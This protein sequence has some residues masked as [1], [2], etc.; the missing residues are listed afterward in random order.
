MRALPLHEQDMYLFHN[1]TNYQAYKM[2]GAH[3][4]DYK[5]SR[6]V[7]FALWVDRVKAV[8]VVGDFN[9][10]QPEPR[11]AMVKQK[12]SNIWTVFIPRLG[13]GD[14]Y[15]Y[16]IVTEQG[17]HILK[18][19]PFAF[20]AELP[21][22]TSSKVSKLGAYKWQ[23]SK[24]Q[25]SLVDNINKPML[26]YE[27]HLGSWRL[28]EN[29]K[30]FSYRRL[31]EELVPYAKEMGYTH[32]E[33]M[34]IAEHPFDGSWGYQ[35]TG[36]YA[37]TS[38]YGNPDDFKY[39]VDTCHQNDISVILD[40]SP[41][42]FC[43]DAH[44][45][46]RFNGY[47]LF[48]SDNTLRAENIEWGT[49]NFDYGRPE[50]LSF[51]ISNAIYWLEEFHV[52]GLRM[53]AVSNMLYLNY[54]RKDGQW[55]PNQYGGTGNL[56]A[57]EFIKNLNMAVFKFF[58]HALMIAEESTDWPRVSH[59]VYMSGLGF[60]YKWNMGWMNDMLKYMSMDPIYRRWHHNQLTFSLMYAFSEKYV[61]PLSHDEV[62]HGKCSL[63]E[64]MPGPYE[65]KFR[66]LKL[67]LAYWMAHPGKKLLFMGG[68]FAQFVEWKYQDSLD[69][70]LLEYPAHRDFHEYMKSLNHFY[71]D[72]KEM[73]EQDC[74]PQGFEW[75]DCHD[76][77]YSIVS[78][79]R[80]GMEK[81]Y[82]IGIFN[83]TPIERHSYKIGVPDS[84]SYRTIFSS[85]PMP[86]EDEFV[87]DAQQPLH[88]R[89]QSIV[90]NLP[91]LSAI[92]L[93]RTEL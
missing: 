69:W 82:I 68:E 25:K 39:F 53:D 7:R 38:R 73:W 15:K 30:P 37:P 20:A 3:V 45:L 71:L 77:E 56:E 75:L 21:P 61:L 17:E 12:N 72:N 41:G 78:F 24:W 49:N 59:P 18:A 88:G 52:D 23:D 4:C 44:G 1:G 16:L 6:G 40:W 83:F 65:E 93:R 31:A 46:R 58:P 42:H 47:N 87:A 89:A 5:G 66:S 54:A 48:E 13:E 92:F 33:L 9:N 27:V 57:M 80:R 43:K 86:N 35:I 74:S 14:L 76:N 26:I 81:D 32:I 55:Q 64:K 10:W 19:D 63:I 90:I 8:F 34:P 85:S 50:V 60:N 91:P 29:G 28:D 79:I 84:G 11:S 36:Y 67:F 22:G 70:H 51:L 2:L 62:V